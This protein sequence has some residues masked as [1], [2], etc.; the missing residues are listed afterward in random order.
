MKRMIFLLAMACCVLSVHGQQIAINGLSVKRELP[1]ETSQWGSDAVTG[2]AT[3]MNGRMGP[4]SRF[5]AYIMAGSA[6]RCGNTPQTAPVQDSFRT[7][8]IRSSDIISALGACSLSPG[9]YTLC[10]QFFNLDYFAISQ[11]TC[12]EFTVASPSNTVYQGPQ[13]ILPANGQVVKK[14][15]ASRPPLLFRWT[16][17][18]PRPQDPDLRYTIRI[19]TIAEGQSQQQALTSSQPVEERELNA[20][21]YNWKMPSGVDEG[22]GLKNFVWTVQARGRNGQ[23]YGTNN[24]TSEASVFSAAPPTPPA[25]IPNCTNVTL[26]QTAICHSATSSV[27]AVI[28]KF[29]NNSGQNIIHYTVT[30][31]NAGLQVGG[32]AVSVINETVTF[33]AGMNQGTAIMFTPTLTGTASF[34]YDIEFADHSTCT[35]GQ[36]VFFAV[37]GA[38]LPPCGCG[39]WGSAPINYAYYPTGIIGGTAQQMTVAPN[40]TI[41]VAQGSAIMPAWGNSFTCQ[42]GCAQA[43]YT[44]DLYKVGNPVAILNVL[45][46]PGNNTSN[47]MGLLAEQGFAECGDYLVVLHAVCGQNGVLSSCTDV[48]TI[49]VHVTC[50]A[51]CGCDPGGWKNLMLVRN[52]TT[53]QVAA[54]HS[55]ITV[56]PGDVISLTGAQSCSTAACNKSNPKVTVLG[57]SGAVYI[58]ATSGLTVNFPAAGSPAPTCGRYAVAFQ[59]TCGT[60]PCFDT[61]FLELGCCSCK[62]NGWDK[63]SY[64]VNGGA[65]QILSN[66]LKRIDLFEGQTLSLTDVQHCSSTTCLQAAQSTATIYTPNFGAVYSSF[67]GTLTGSF[68]MAGQAAPACGALYPVVFVAMC[69][70]TTCRDT[71][72][73]NLICCTCSAWSNVSFWKNNVAQAAFA[74]GTTISYPAGSTIKLRSTSSCSSSQC[75][76]TDTLARIYGPNGQLYSSFQTTTVTFPALGTTPPCGLYRVAFRGKCG[77]NECDSCQAWINV[78]CPPVCSCPG[79]WIVSYKQNGW[80]RVRNCNDTVTVNQYSVFSQL[81]G[82]MICANGC[83]ATNTRMEIFEP[84]A[85]TPLVSITHLYH[86]PAFSFTKCG[87]YKIR[88][89]ARCGTN[90][91]S[92]TFYVRVKCQCIGCNNRLLE[93]KLVT[94]TVINDANP[95]SDRLNLN[96]N[97]QAGPFPIT[98]VRLELVHVNVVFPAGCLGLT[99]NTAAHDAQGNFRGLPSLTNT[100]DWLPPVTAYGHEID[101]V[102]M[103]AAGVSMTP[104]GKNA[105]F[106]VGIPNHTYPT[107]CKPSYELCFRVMVRDAACTACEKLVCITIGPNNYVVFKEITLPPGNMSNTTPLYQ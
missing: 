77:G 93:L 53:S 87:I 32:T 39:Q 68:P 90:D 23:Y 28:P 37:C 50:A 26:Y 14:E 38:A 73:I 15:G 33:G 8:I 59:Q 85:T 84:G 70:T 51:S 48:R 2:V 21:Q 63:I 107:C 19:Y 96:L 52:G 49:N 103:T 60:V 1:A 7:R 25:V 104:P 79:N 66:S 10:V 43:F 40:G 67:T 18:V 76:K 12:R 65:N 35:I 56:S 27:Y 80:L 72:Y 17:V 36:R 6:R 3:G 105:K 95:A 11:E 45:T 106:V 13:P 92:C 55:T 46:T 99:Y 101:W 20:T 5:V 78:P 47:S 54:N 64:Q 58:A 88:Y 29:I 41:T 98:E 83:L 61:V 94:A 44:A 24:G 30:S 57:P 71:A 89:S 86:I 9:Q 16:P 31:A 97:L 81:S 62:V 69:G 74:C 4:A 82:Q 100:A 42:G 91:C 75:A 102:S 34:R 22:T